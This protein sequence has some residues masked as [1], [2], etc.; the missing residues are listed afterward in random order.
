[1]DTG[2]N[3]HSGNNGNKREQ[4]VIAGTEAMPTAAIILSAT[5][6]A[7]ITKQAA[8]IIT[9]HCISLYQ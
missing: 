1:M 8:V 3:N 4:K 9:N 6:I 2:G 5:M 7:S